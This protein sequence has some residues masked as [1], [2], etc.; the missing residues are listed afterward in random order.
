MLPSTGSVCVSAKHLSI[1][2]CSFLLVHSL[3][4]GKLSIRMVRVSGKRLSTHCI[5]GI[6][7]W[8][9]RIVFSTVFK[10]NNFP[11]YLNNLNKQ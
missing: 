3:L 9:I 11:L 6:H 1:Y 4:F 5:C 7:I 10:M 2:V 8:N